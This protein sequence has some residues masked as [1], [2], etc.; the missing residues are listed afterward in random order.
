MIKGTSIA[1]IGGLGFKALSISVDKCFRGDRC[2]QPK[3]YHHGML[4]QE[5]FDSWE[6]Q[7]TVLENQY[8]YLSNPPAELTRSQVILSSMDELR[9]EGNPFDIAFRPRT[10]EQGR[11]FDAFLSQEL[12]YC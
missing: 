9:D 4:T 11:A 8:P 1:A 10:L 12:R 3:C 2:K 5:T 7:E 6:E